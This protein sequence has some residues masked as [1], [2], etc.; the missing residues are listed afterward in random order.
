MCL[1]MK[2]AWQRLSKPL[3]HHPCK[4][5]HEANEQIVSFRYLTKQGPVSAVLSHGSR[6]GAVKGVLTQVL[7]E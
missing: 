6:S 4:R 5:Q 3:D 2:L 7:P 1:G